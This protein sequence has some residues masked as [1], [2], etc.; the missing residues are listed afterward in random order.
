[1]SNLDIDAIKSYLI[2]VGCKIE[3]PILVNAF[4]HC[5]YNPDPGVQGRIRTQFKDYVNRL[6]TVSLENNMK[7]IILRPEFRPTSNQHDIEHQ[8]N[9]VDHKPQ[10]NKISIET[11]RDV[12]HVNDRSQILAPREILPNRL[13]LS[14]Q[15]Q[16][17]VYPSSPIRL[18]TQVPDVPPPI[19]R[20]QRSLDVAQPLSVSSPTR[21]TPLVHSPQSIPGLNGISTPDKQP[22]LSHQTSSQESSALIQRLHS[23]RAQQNPSN[24]DQPSLPRDQ[25]IRQ[26]QEK[27]RGTVDR[28]AGS[29]D[30][31]D[32]GKT[33]D[34]ED[35]TIAPPSSDPVASTRANYIAQISGSSRT[36]SLDA[37][38]MP[39]PRPPP[40]RRQS[41]A[42]LF[43]NQVSMISKK[44]V[45]SQSNHELSDLAKKSLG[46][47]REHALKLNSTSVGDIQSMSNLVKSHSMREPRLSRDSF[48]CSI[49]S[50]SQRLGYNPSMRSRSSHREDESDS[51]SFQP[52]D[53]L[54]RKWTTEACNCNYN[55]LVT[56][57]REDPKL[58]SYKDTVGYTA[59][60]WAAKVG[61]L[62][63]IRLVAGTYGV[64][65]DMKSNAG[66][67]PLHIAYMFG[68]NEAAN[69]LLNSYNANPMIRDFSG[70]RPQQ[71][72]K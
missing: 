25:S 50:A 43:N 1:M 69:L 56:L 68:K 45:E 57:L 64:S 48:M 54:R 9:N 33:T 58:A 52:I 6:A 37:T 17:H 60:H 55:G 53:Q 11:K 3:Y 51:S 28:A 4:K 16:N 8:I 61:N 62:D 40:R 72:A 23:Q 29:Q 39:P 30:T 27:R 2:K 41:N 32:H 24:F 49:S 20:H 22:P 38:Q 21:K 19:P 66:Y 46:R 59:L 5:L 7:F 67:T 35:T 65:P 15:Q 12:C 31:I 18:S 42:S 10:P 14:P 34:S 63:I 70:K 44:P 71:L 36:N 13:V 47:V 26:T